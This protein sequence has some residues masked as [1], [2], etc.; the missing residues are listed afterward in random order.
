MADGHP[1]SMDGVMFK[2]VAQTE[3]MR[4]YRWRSMVLNFHWNAFR[5]QQFRDIGKICAQ[6]VADHGQMSSIVVMRGDISLNLDAETRREGAA[7]TK[8]FELTNTGQA[9]VMEADGFKA[10]LARSLI[11]GVNLLARSKSRQRVFKEPKEAAEWVCA[12]EEQPAEIRD[13]RTRVWAELERLVGN[14]PA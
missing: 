13:A 6:V 4:L 10:S 11:T 7:L 1:A 12:I 3:D 9:L 2:L 8:E 5:A 14:L